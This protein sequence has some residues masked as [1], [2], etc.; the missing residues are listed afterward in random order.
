MNRNLLRSLVYQSYLQTATSTDKY[1]FDKSN[2]KIQS[3]EI[4]PI[5]QAFFK[6]PVNERDLNY[7]G[8]VMIFNKNFSHLS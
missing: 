2:F 5:V 3:F 4:L 6:Q 7:A 1:M 8:E